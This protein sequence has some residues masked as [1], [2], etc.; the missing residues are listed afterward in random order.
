ML[1]ISNSSRERLKAIFANSAYF[2]EGSEYT[3]SSAKPFAEIL[4]DLACYHSEE[5]VQGSL[6]LL[7]RSFSA[8]DSLFHSALQ[9]QLLLT[10]QSKK[11]SRQPCMAVPCMAAPCMAVPCLTPAVVVQVFSEIDKRLPSLRRLLSLDLG[12]TGRTEVV[13]ILQI[14][15]EMCHLPSLEAE[16]HTQNQKILYN[17]GE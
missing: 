8:E 11:V 5:L 1:R 12:D 2:F 7:N 13:D 4:V 3:R 9:T 6:H 17:F 14:F 16:P 10:E 15:T